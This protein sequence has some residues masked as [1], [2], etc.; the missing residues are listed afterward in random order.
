MFE[1]N[2]PPL[3]ELMHHGIKG[4]KWGIRKDIRSGAKKGMTKARNAYYVDPTK[5]ERA[6]AAARRRTM[7]DDELN[8]RIERLQKEKKLK[9][10]TA[11]DI[12]PGRQALKRFGKAT[13]GVAGTAAGAAAV[14]YIMGSRMEGTKFRD[15]D[16]VD[17]GKHVG[18]VLKKVKK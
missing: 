3:E 12:S 2:K 5:R 14:K 4:M 7:S 9:E 18:K 1:D 17:V 13:L 6:K 16:P 8:R 11:D 15:I 10:L